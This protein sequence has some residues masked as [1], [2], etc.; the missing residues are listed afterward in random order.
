MGP[1]DSSELFRLLNNYRSLS[2]LRTSDLVTQIKGTLQS[3]SKNDKSQKRDDVLLIWSD[4][5]PELS[6]GQPLD[7]H[8]KA[9]RCQT[10][11]ACIDQ[12]IILAYVQIL[13]DRINQ[14][15][16]SF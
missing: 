9:K 6:I 7:R 16:I 5:L 10:H 1:S 2:E 3:S 12:R 4:A 13:L 11:T 8:Q 15:S 14:R